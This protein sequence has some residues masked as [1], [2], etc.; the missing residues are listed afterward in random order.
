MYGDYAK[1]IWQSPTE[2]CVKS[3]QEYPAKGQG[4]V[5]VKCQL[6]YK[7]QPRYFTF[8]QKEQ[9]DLVTGLLLEPF[10]KLCGN[11]ITGLTRA[12][13]FHLVRPCKKCFDPMLHNLVLGLCGRLQFLDW[14]TVAIHCQLEFIDFC[15]S[16]CSTS[17][18]STLGGIGFRLLSLMVG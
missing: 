13:S 7:T 4:L 5:V 10:S 9:I 8:E 16:R 6:L 12:I 14:C 2:L 1:G 18:W 11:I 17:W 3:Q 15:T